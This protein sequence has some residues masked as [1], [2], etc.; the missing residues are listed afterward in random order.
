MPT[1]CS[2]GVQ[3]QRQRKVAGRALTSFLRTAASSSCHAET[4]LFACVYVGLCMGPKRSKHLK[5]SHATCTRFA[6]TLTCTCLD[7]HTCAAVARPCMSCK[8]AYSIATWHVCVRLAVRKRPHNKHNFDIHREF[9]VRAIRAPP[10]VSVPISAGCLCIH[11]RPPQSRA[12]HSR[13]RFECPR[14]SHS[15]PCFH[16]YH[17]RSP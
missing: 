6:H 1:G 7:M 5:V 12:P 11:I 17:A 8:H 15:S 16:P 4:A 13:A 10:L 3:E 2:H 9:C 14:P